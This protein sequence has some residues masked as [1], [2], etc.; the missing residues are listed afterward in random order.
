M[1][2][3][4]IIRAGGRNFLFKC[5]GQFALTYGLNFVKA[6]HSFHPP[7]IRGGFLFLKFEQRRGS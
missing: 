3:S 2:F 1:I 7:R 4:V 6:I 5:A